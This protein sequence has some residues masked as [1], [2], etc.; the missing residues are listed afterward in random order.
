MTTTKQGVP[1]P[2]TAPGAVRESALALANRVRLEAAEYKRRCARGDVEI[3]DA[4]LECEHHMTLGALLKSFPR[5][6]GVRAE[7]LCRNAGMRTLDVQ[8]AP[9]STHEKR[10]ITQ[11]ERRRLVDALNGKFT[12]CDLPQ[13]VYRSDDLDL[14]KRLEAIDCTPMQV[15]QFFGISKRDAINRLRIVG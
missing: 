2:A 6:G 8:M 4:I 12:R 9:G 13:I 10:S 11:A 3:I 15:A 14:L 7:R 5:W 1:M